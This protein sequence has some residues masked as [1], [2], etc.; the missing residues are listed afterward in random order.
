[1]QD[2]ILKDYADDFGKY[3]T[4]DTATKIRLIWDSIPS[5]IAKE[6][7]KFIFSHVKAGAPLNPEG[8]DRWR[9]AQT[10]F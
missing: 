9:V 6:N 2:R 7:N 3:T 1:M 4:P 10:R 5:Q 8:G